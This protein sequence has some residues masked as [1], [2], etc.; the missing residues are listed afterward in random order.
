M[1]IS[2]TAELKT[3]ATNLAQE[4]MEEIISLNYEEISTGTIESRHRLGSD[5]S[6]PFYNYERETIVSLVDGDLNEVV[7]DQGMKKIVVNLYWSSKLGGED[8]IQIISLVS[9]L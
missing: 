8:Q 3:I 6:D 2:R 1:Q 4:K 5:G 9:Q 7:E